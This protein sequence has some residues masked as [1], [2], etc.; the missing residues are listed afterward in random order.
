MDWLSTLHSAQQT[1][2]LYV[3]EAIHEYYGDVVC[4][5]VQ[6]NAFSEADRADGVQSTWVRFFE[7]VEAEA[8]P[9]TDKDG[10][11]L[12]ALLVKL[13]ASSA[14]KVRYHRRRE[15]PCWS[16]DISTP[17][18]YRLSAIVHVMATASTLATWLRI[19]GHP[20]HEI[21]RRDRRGAEELRRRLRLHGL[22]TVQTGGRAAVAP[23]GSEARPTRPAA[24]YGLTAQIEQGRRLLCAAVESVSCPPDP[25]PFEAIPIVHKRRPRSKDGLPGFVNRIGWV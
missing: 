22:R 19:A 17:P 9:E 10:V 11:V 3:L 13:A 23:T 20:L 8:L 15:I 25:R 7:M 5:A 18:E 12:E 1:E 6:R 2:R 4:E 16:A 21:R 24:A 14:R